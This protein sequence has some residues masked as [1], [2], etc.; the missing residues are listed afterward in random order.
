MRISF[1]L[2]GLSRVPVGGYKIV[3]EYGNR[4]A[5]RGHHVTVIHP[6]A[7]ALLRAAGGAPSPWPERLK[8][9]LWPFLRRPRTG[10]RNARLVPW[11]A[12]RPGVHLRL[13]PDLSEKFIPD[14]DAIFATAWQTAHPVH[15]LSAAKGAKYYFI[16]HYETAEGA[17]DEARVRATWKLPLHKIVIA[18]WLL[19]IARDLGQAGCT[20]YIPHGLDFSRF[21]MATP[22]EHRAPRVGMLYHRDQWKGSADAVAAL[23]AARAQ[24]PPLQAVA[25]GTPPRPPD[26][27]AW[28]EYLQTPSPHDLNA[29]YNGCSIFLQASWSEGWGLP[30]SEA[31]ACGC[32][33]LTTDNGGSREYTEDG[34]TA[35]VAP[36]QNPPALTAQLLRLLRDD[37]LRQRLAHAGHQH[38]RQFT[39]Q[40]AVDS[41]EF[42]IDS[43]RAVSTLQLVEQNKSVFVD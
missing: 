35:L 24:V 40:R 20:T 39:W 15:A 5:A 34:K 42:L 6:Y 26:F 37:A 32:A 9:R 30:A 17:P 18:Q 4:L 23:A 22:L 8:Q 16:Q 31:M 10:K 12:V 11:F 7:P 38:I 19:Q 25:F 36:I 21:K 43:D 3:Y 27:P 41:L 29:L 28:M 2:P 1:V 13:V 33:L 14:A